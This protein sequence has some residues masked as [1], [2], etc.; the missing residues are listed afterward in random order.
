MKVMYNTIW[1]FT[2]LLFVIALFLGCNKNN[3]MFSAPYEE[4]LPPLD[5]EINPTDKMQPESGKTGVETIMRIKGLDKY[6]DK[7]IIRFNGEKAQIV[8]LTADYVK[9]KVPPFASTGVL[10]VAIDDI[11]FFGPQ[12][13]VLGNVSIDPTFQVG[14]GTNNTV[15]DVLFLED[16]KMIFTGS[17]TNYNN[18]G[19]IR[20]INRLVRTFA[21]GTYDASFRIGT[22]ANNSLNSILKL[23]N[24]YFLA[25]S[26]S[27]Y[28]QRNSDISNLTRIYTTGAIDT[29]GIKPFRRPG[30]TDTLKYYPTFNG[31]FDGNIGNIYES[32]GKILATGN[33]RYYIHRTYD[34]PNRLETRD[35][36]I[37]DSTEI[38]HI[39]RLNLDGSLDKSFRFGADGKAMAGGN[40]SVATVYH[41]SGALKG[42]ILAYGSFNRFDGQSAGYITRLNAD[43][44]LDAT[45][46]PGGVGA[47]YNVSSVTYNN[48]TNKYMVVGDFSK[49]NGVAAIKVVMLNANGTVD[50]SFQAKTFEGGSPFYAMQLND[51]LVVVSGDFARYSNIARNGFMILNSNGELNGDYNTSGYFSGY[52]NK[53]VETKTED[54]KRALLLMGFFGR[55][56]N[57][58]VHN[59]IRIK[60]EQ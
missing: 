50:Q 44:T 38:R 41:N 15:S 27:G 16:G 43:G 4:G 45:F 36:I 25:G 30:Q 2:A 31:G 11:V 48:V 9:L 58:E 55:F 24:Y 17:F 57:E 40:G 10:S 23:G 7:A 20:P 60:L 39:A 35:T 3:K 21:D 46:N 32:E 13:T 14:V 6:K 56:N 47:D 28:G 29:M 12:F 37:L 42:K 33:F 5:I 8:E 26:F 1:K 54:G 49:Y 53:V 18:K 51:G 59:L 19:S 34:K 52:I 22:G